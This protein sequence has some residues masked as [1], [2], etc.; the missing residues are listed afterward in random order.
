MFS[1][2]ESMV[3][4]IY[5][6]IIHFFVLLFRLPDHVGNIKTW[7]KTQWELKTVKRIDMKLTSLCNA[8]NALITFPERVQFPT[9]TH[10]CKRFGGRAFSIESH[11]SLQQALE[12]TKPIYCGLEGYPELGMFQ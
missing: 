5:S 6:Y 10:F 8:K 7:T 11:A 3:C 9:L 1:K 4:N 2:S 12:V